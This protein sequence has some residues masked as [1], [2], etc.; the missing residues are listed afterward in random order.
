M[1]AEQSDGQDHRHHIHGGFGEGPRERQQTELQRIRQPRDGE[2][3]Q[4]PFPREGP[5]RTE[6]RRQFFQQLH[7]GN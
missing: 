2:R 6:T 7:S 1:E 5:G 4:S 3:D